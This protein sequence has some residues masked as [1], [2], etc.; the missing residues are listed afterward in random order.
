MQRS[1]ANILIG[2]CFK[3]K[4]DFYGND[5]GSKQASDEYDCQKKCQNYDG[6]NYWTYTPGTCWM[7]KSASGRAS[8]NHAISGPKFC[9]GKLVFL[10]SSINF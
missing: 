3:Q 8:N 9:Q 4:T 5:V 6:C 2:P 10:S 7:K 1:I